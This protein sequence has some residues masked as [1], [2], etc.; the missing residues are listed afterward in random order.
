MD[1]WE[2][3]FRPKE[4][5]DDN[6]EGGITMEDLGKWAIACLPGNIRISYD[7]M[8][9]KLGE[10]DKNKTPEAYENIILAVEKRLEQFLIGEGK[11]IELDLS[12]EILDRI[13][14][15]DGITDWVMIKEIGAQ[16]YLGMFSDG[17]EAF[18]SIRELPNGRWKYSVGAK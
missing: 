10:I 6:D 9:K 3:F 16:A 11:T 13:T 12:Y 14:N 1:G 2:G 15:Q 5:N 4:E 8:V 7:E 17:H 18:V